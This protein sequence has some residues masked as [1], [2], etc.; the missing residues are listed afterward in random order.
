MRSKCS[1]IK[2]LGEQ[3]CTVPSV[4]FPFYF[5]HTFFFSFPNVTES[6]R[7]CP[8][9]SSNGPVVE[10]VHNLFVVH[11]QCHWTFNLQAQGFN[12]MFTVYHI[13]YTTSRRYAF[14]F[15]YT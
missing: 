3:I 8:G 9:I 7:N 12:E 11:V 13:S 1:S 2:V 5:Q 10:Y 14:C 6:Y 15:G 4:T